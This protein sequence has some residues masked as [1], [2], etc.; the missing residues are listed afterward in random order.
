[1]STVY[2]LLVPVMVLNL[3]VPLSLAPQFI[4]LSGKKN[5]FHHEKMSPLKSVYNEK[6]LSLH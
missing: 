4:Y 6:L 1:M 2:C 3:V 5:H